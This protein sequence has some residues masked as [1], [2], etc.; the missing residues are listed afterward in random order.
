MIP[1]ISLGAAG[2]KATMH[3]SSHQGIMSEM[4]G[5]TKLFTS[6]A[7]ILKGLLFMHELIRHIVLFFGSENMTKH[8]ARACENIGPRQ[9]RQVAYR[10]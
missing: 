9:Q 5:K 8:K 6:V 2:A 7:S 1:V 3:V 10:Y 4:R